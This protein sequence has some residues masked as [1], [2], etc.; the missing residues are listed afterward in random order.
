M[1]DE[2]GNGFVDLEE[3]A[4]VHDSGD[5]VNFDSKHCFPVEVHTMVVGRLGVDA[6]NVSVMWTTSTSRRCGTSVHWGS[7]S[8]VY[9]NTSVGSSVTYRAGDLYNTSLGFHGWIHTCFMVVYGGESP[10]YYVVGDGE[11]SWSKEFALKLQLRATEGAT[12]PTRIAFGADWGTY[13]P[14]GWAVA[15]Q[16]ERAHRE[17][18]GGFHAVVAVGDLSYATIGV[19]SMADEY[20]VVWDAWLRIMQPLATQMPLVAVVGNHETPF[21]YDAFRTRFFMPET[22]GAPRNMWFSVCIGRVHMVVVSTQHAYHPGSPQFVWLAKQLAQ[23]DSAEQRLATPFLI[24]ATHRPMYC[25]D[26][27]E[28]D[29]ARVGAPEQVA[30]E[31]LLIAHH[32]DAF[33]A[34]HHHVYERTCIMRNGTCVGSGGLLHLTIGTAGAYYVEGFQVQPAWSMSRSRSYG[35]GS[36]EVFNATHARWKYEPLH[37]LSEADEVWLVR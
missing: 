18:G 31:Q 13:I 24:V 23:A 35:F 36:L 20:E 29:Q 5:S 11:S 34:G 4:L 15:R 25:S 19:P 6:A 16:V 37:K 33:V 9:V 8:G 17:S 32:V 7:R 30:L 12:P 22:A 3:L 26:T 2:D 28:E 10:V 1:L 14:A 21:G 27:F